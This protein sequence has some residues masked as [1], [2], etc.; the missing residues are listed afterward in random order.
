MSNLPEQ[1]RESLM[2]RIKLANEEINA[3]FDVRMEPVINLANRP[4]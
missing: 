3:V 1:E 4:K 2:A